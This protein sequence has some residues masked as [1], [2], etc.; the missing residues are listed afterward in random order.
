MSSLLKFEE[1]EDAPQFLREYLLHALQ[2]LDGPAGNWS[3][4]AAATAAALQAPSADALFP[5]LIDSF[6]GFASPE[7]SDYVH[8][9]RAT[10]LS[11]NVSAFLLQ[12]LRKG[13]LLQACDTARRLLERTEPGQQCLPFS[14]LDR[15]LDACSAVL[16]ARNNQSATAA[17]AAAVQG[18]VTALAASH[19]ALVAAVEQ[20]FS[21]LLVVE[22]G[23][24]H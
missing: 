14:V 24:G 20:Y 4:H 22:A 18:Q 10:G 7:D 15:L 23:G 16:S 21:Q 11:G 17:A 9:P 3:L 5:A 6:G 8:V 12:L 13:Q 19:G 2:C 1:S